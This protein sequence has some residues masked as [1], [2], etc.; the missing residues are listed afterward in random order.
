M[1]K[2]SLQLFLNK[3]FFL[4]LAG[5]TDPPEKCIICG[6]DVPN[7]WPHVKGHR[8]SR[9]ERKLLRSYYKLK[10]DGSR[11]RLVWTGYREKVD[12]PLNQF[13]EIKRPAHKLEYKERNFRR[14]LT[15]FRE[16]QPL[17]IVKKAVNIFLKLQTNASPKDV[18]KRLQDAG[19]NLEE[20]HVTFIYKKVKS[21]FIN[22]LK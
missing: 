16:P 11:L 3:K 15:T 12:V 2:S 17:K 22:I 10:Q 4:H 19:Y 9:N 13:D 1:R 14:A 20:K 8:I 18:A 5:T 6:D 21:A 7:I